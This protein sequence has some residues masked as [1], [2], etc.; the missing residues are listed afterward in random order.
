MKGLFTVV[1][2]TASENGGFVTTITADGGTKKIF[3]QNIPV[4]HRFC[5][6]TPEEVAIGTEQELDLADFI[7]KK[8]E[9]SSATYLFAK[10]ADGE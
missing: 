10:V 1:K 5:I 9:E 4:K 6:N 7:Q 2:S 8:Y 3:G